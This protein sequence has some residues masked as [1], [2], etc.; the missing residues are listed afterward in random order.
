MWQKVGLFLLPFL[1][2][3]ILRLLRDN[4]EKLVDAVNDAVN[5]PTMDEE[6]EE[7]LFNSIY[8]FIENLIIQKL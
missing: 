8:N 5:I 2:G 1:K 6:D 4:Q 7:K 3:I